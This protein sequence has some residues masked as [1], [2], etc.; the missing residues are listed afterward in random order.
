MLYIFL[1]VL[2][3]VIFRAWLTFNLISSGDMGFF[4]REQILNYFNPPFMWET[5]RNLGFGGNALLSQGVYFYNLPLGILGNYLDFGI[6]ERIIWF[7]PILL[8]GFL[9]PLFLASTIKLFPKNFFPLV[10]FI[11]FLN[12]YFFIIMGGGQLTV[13]LGYITIPIAF[14]LFINAVNNFKLFKI[15]FFNLVFTSLILFDFRFVYIFTVILFLYAFF[16]CITITSLSEILTLSKKYIT[17]FFFSVMVILG[18]QS[19]WLLPFL[20]FRN[21]PV[22]SVTTAYTSAQAVKYFSFAEFEHSFSLLHPLWP[23]NIFGKVGFMKPEFILL[24]I[25]AYSGLFFLR[26]SKINPDQIGIKSQKLNNNETMQQWNNDK[27]ILFFALL[28]L[29]G[30][31]LAKGAKEPFGDVYIWL[32]DNIPGFVMFRDSTKWYTLTALSYSILIPYSIY[33]IYE[34][35]KS[36]NKFSIFPTSLKLHG[37]SKFHNIFLI[38]VIG[39]LL[40]LIRPAIVGEVGGTLKTVIVPQEYI[41][42][43]N[44]LI[45]DKNFSRV[46]W[47]PS[48][49]RFTFYSD[50]HPAI[51]GKDFFDT[52]EQYG[53]IAALQKNNTEELLQESGV[54]YV[55]IPDDTQ[56]EIFL[57]DRRYDPIQYNV[58]A[59]K[60]KKISYLRE[61]NK[62]GK[63][64]VFEIDNPK[65]HFWSSYNNLKIKYEFINPTSYNVKVENAKTGD[66]IVFVESFD[67][68]WVAKMG[69]KIINSKSYEK[70]FN[71]F[72]LPT[73]GDY[74]FEVLYKPQELVKTG[75]IISFFTF[76]SIL[77]LMIFLL[78]RGKIARKL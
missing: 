36:H 63:I 8:A 59:E 54:K 76:L 5:F 26:R 35:L 33:K 73:D 31:F 58:T 11:Y 70:R 32:F 12:T 10:T 42:L 4:H 75:V 2:I 13:A 60:L 71:S 66:E 72:I 69:D 30:A 7:W 29:I 41:K 23:E 64:I 46:L 45:Q 24:P 44:F 65:D 56:K 47:V 67:K 52:Y 1:L 53:V 34:W 21:N 25:L 43:K 27:L 40:F 3:G 68:N 62:F 55:I 22:E 15:L 9:S 14:A 19:Y 50:I 61:V 48:L 17:I 78:I 57:R 49:Q 38:L 16:C 74:S 28:G 20:F 6:I 37:A 18:T 77:F 51:S 39:Y